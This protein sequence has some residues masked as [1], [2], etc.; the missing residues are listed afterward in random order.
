[1]P[2]VDLLC[3]KYLLKYNLGGARWSSKMAYVNTFLVAN[4]E[5]F[6]LCTRDKSESKLF[7]GLMYAYM[8]P[9]NSL[10]SNLSRTLKEGLD[11]YRKI[12]SFFQPWLSVSLECSRREAPNEDKKKKKTFSQGNIII[13]LENL[14]WLRE[15]QVLVVFTIN[16]HTV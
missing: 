5:R 16:I 14:F 1:M 10:D 11:F 2:F 9:K 6:F 4:L 12:G 3:I 8:R 13:F 7:L 15:N